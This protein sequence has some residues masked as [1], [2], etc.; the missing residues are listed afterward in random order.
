MPE[1]HGRLGAAAPAANTDTSLY[2]APAGNKATAK[3]VLCNRGSTD[4]TARLA[5]VDGAIASVANEDYLFFDMALPANGV[6]V[7]ERIP[8]AAGHSLL[9]RFGNAN[10][11]AHAL[12]VQE[13]I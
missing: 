12:G 8:V 6:I 1:S 13:D 5:Y 9:V 11:S 7:E 3:V 10:C 2:H 4:T